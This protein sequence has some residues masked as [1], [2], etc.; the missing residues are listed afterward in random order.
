MR[1][2][3]PIKLL[4][5]T[6]LIAVPLLGCSNGNGVATNSTVSPSIMPSATPEETASVPPSPEEPSSSPVSSES[7]PPASSLPP[8]KLGTVTAMRLADYKTG[9]TGGEGWIAR[10]RNGG[11]SWTKQWEGQETVQQLFALN[12]IEAWATLDKGDAKELSLIRTTDGGS[13]WSAAGTVPNRDFLHFVSAN[14]AFSGNDH[15]TDGGKT[16]TTY[17]LPAETVGNAYFHDKNNGW[18]VTQTN[19]KFDFRRTTDGAKS[20][21]VVYTRATEA[22]VTGTVIRSAGK[23]DAWIEL[24]GDS[25]MSQTSYSLFHT[26]SGGKSWTPVLANNQAG[27]GPAPGFKMSEETKVPRNDGSSPGTLNVVNTKVAFMGG[28]C[29]AC[30]LSNTMGKTTDGGATWV[31]LKAAFPGYGPQFIGAQDA[32][33]IWWINTENEQPSVLYTSSDGGNTWNKTYTFDK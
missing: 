10:T 33:H 21:K 17:K 30:D 6:I 12:N 20:W 26:E 7:P 14:E 4:F 2:R 18:I 28:R 16:W 8:P 24:I 25:G 23:N 22:P 29:S 32:D 27:S 15:T 11:N 5:V 19:G 9:W 1:F 3:N 13:N 31:N